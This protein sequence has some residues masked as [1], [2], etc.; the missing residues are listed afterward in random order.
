MVRRF[1]GT[2]LIALRRNRGAWAL[3][4]GVLRART[5]LIALADDDSWWAPGALAAAA[6]VLAA[7]PGVGTAGRP[8]PGRPGRGPDAVNA[9]MAAA[10]PRRACRDPGS[11]AS[12]AAGRWSGVRP[13][14]RSEDSPGCCLSAARSS[15]SPMTWPQRLG[16]LLPPGHRRLPSPLRCPSARNPAV[17]GGAEPRAGGLVARPLWCALTETGRL[18]RRAGTGPRR[19]PGAGQPDRPAAAWPCS[20]GVRCRPMWKRPSGP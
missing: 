14:W 1:S 10:R 13:T 4:L 15:C 16:R 12:W 2:E 11:W 5:P 7:S 18:A 20:A 3:N 6:A 9:V 17:P 19:R 8:H